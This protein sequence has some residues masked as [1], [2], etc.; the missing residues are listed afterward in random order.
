[1]QARAL[2][3]RGMIILVL[4]L[5]WIPLLM[6]PAQSYSPTSQEWWLPALLAV[7]VLIADVEL[8]VR[9]G[10]AVWPWLLI[11][12]AQGFNIIS[13]LMMLWPHSTQSVGGD[14][15]PNWPYILITFLSMALSALVI[16]YTEKPQVRT[17]LLR[18]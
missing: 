4:V 12:F 14:N 7:M 13:R 15:I 1:M 17:G 5:Q 6:F 8:I 11:S 16:W 9:H 3:S 2:T 10:S 18:A